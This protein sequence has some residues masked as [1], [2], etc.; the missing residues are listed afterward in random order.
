LNTAVQEVA[1]DKDVECNAKT[2]K[3]ATRHHRQ[4]DSLNKIHSKHKNQM[5]N[6]YA[7]NVKVCQFILTV[8]IESTVANQLCY[9]ISQVAVQLANKYRLEAETFMEKNRK[10]KRE[11]KQKG[12]A[13]EL[14][15][16]AEKKALHL[17]YSTIANKRRDDVFWL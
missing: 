10:L 17:Y 12:E 5:Q 9:C 6:K 7:N 14:K 11:F 16:K 4:I 2:E 3:M 1:A 13:I 15:H 8:Q